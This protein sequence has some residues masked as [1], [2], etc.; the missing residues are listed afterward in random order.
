MSQSI[1]I[2]S[3]PMDRRLPPK[4]RERVLAR[5]GFAGTLAPTFENLRAIYATWCRGVP[6][7]NVRKLI[8]VRAGNSRSAARKYGGGFS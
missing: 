6:F 7:D 2:A 4:L 5:L 3:S 8:H 1:S